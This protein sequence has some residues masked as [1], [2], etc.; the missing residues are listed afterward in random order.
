[1]KSSASVYRDATRCPALAVAWEKRT[2]GVAIRSRFADY[3]ELTRPRIA[4]LVLFTVAVG[5]WLA[6]AGGGSG[7][8]RGMKLKR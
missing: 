1:M 3:V 2:S 5:P 8:A 4:L 7:A 6:S